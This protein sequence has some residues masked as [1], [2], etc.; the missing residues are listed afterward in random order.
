M[1]IYGTH[2][3]PVD[4]YRAATGMPPNAQPATATSGLLAN[5]LNLGDHM[6]GLAAV[7]DKRYKDGGQ[8]NWET[9]SAPPP[10][11]YPV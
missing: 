2:G 8:T 11:S 1:A 10:S 9:V 3:F 4:K 7:L 5:P 6:P